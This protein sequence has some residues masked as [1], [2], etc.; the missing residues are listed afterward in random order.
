MQPG[1]VFTAIN[2]AG[3]QAQATCTETT[4]HHC[5]LRIT[6]IQPHTACNTPH[7]TVA[8]ATPKGERADFLVEKCTEL[9]VS[10]IV[11]ITCTRSVSIPQPNSAKMQRFQRIAEAATMQCKRGSV[12][13]ITAPVSLQDFV[14]T[15]TSTHKW[16]AHPQA[17]STPLAQL[18]PASS[19]IVIGPEGG[20]TDQEL[21]FLQNAGYNPLRIGSFVLRTETAAIAASA[22]LENLFIKQV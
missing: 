18:K 3:L 14:A 5:T 2:G 4:S 6:H 8:T 10:H 21:E 13:L 19:S 17:P 12:P 9:G 16:V 22:W 20:F 11:W 1:D 7:I 15:D